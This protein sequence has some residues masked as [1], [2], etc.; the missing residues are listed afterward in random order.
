MSFEEKL[1]L[2]LENANITQKKLAKDLNVA[3]S[4]MSEASLILLCSKK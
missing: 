3:T 4:T 2:L 1:R